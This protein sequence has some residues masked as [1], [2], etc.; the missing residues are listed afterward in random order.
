ML[1]IQ[2]IFKAV[3]NWATH[4]WFAIIGNPLVPTESDFNE[5]AE[6]GIGNSD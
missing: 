2:S 5:N 6:R 4:V 1:K 3:K